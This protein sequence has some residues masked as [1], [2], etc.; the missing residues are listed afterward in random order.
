MTGFDTNNKYVIMNTAGI[1]CYYAKEESDTC[2][3]MCCGNRRSFTF[4]ILDNMG[5]EVARVHRE[6]KCCAGSS[7]CAFCCDCAAY[8]VTIEAPVGNPIGYVKQAGSFW[9]ACY[10]VLDE[11]HEPVLKIEG[12]CCILDGAFCCSDTEFKLLTLDGD[13]IGKIAKKYSGFVK[14]AATTADNFGMSCK[15]YYNRTIFI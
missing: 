14:E 12:P 1:Q 5:T 4:H 3:R 10:N 13:Q 6:F 7:L 9:K 11:N 2:M 8:E 15:F